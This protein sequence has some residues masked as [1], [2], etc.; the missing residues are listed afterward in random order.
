LFDR[1]Y[2][3]SPDDRRDYG[4]ERLIVTGEI[5]NCVIAVVYTRRGRRRRILSARKATAR[6]Q[7]AYYQAIYPEQVPNE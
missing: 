2:L 7:E 1:P 3:E 5:H 4:E 6:E